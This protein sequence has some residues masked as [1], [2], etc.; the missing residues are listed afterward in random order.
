MP[1]VIKRLPEAIAN[2]I[3]AGEVVQRPASVIKELMENAV[4]AGASSISVYVSDAGK[5]LIQVLDD[6]QGMSPEDAELCFERHATSKIATIEDLF[7]IRTKGFRGEALASI[8]SIARVELKTCQ[9]DSEVGTRILM[10]GGKQQTKEECQAP[11]GTSISVQH[12]FYNVP[13][14]RNFLKSNTVE[15]RH[16]VDEFQRIALAHP[17]IHFRLEHNG[18]ELFH[19]RPGKARQR[20]VAVLGKS[21]NEK[22][23]PVEESTS[24]LDVS[25]FVGKPENAR[26]TRGDQ[27]FFINGRYFKSPYLNHAISTLYEDLIPEK[28]FPLYVLFLELDPSR[29]D[30]NVHPTKQE[31]KF[32]DEKIVYTFVQAAVRHALSKY[33]VVPTLDFDMDSEFAN[34]PAFRKSASTREQVE[35]DNSSS[36]DS[37]A[38]PSGWHGGPGRL[39]AGAAQM[40]AIGGK[41]PWEDLFQDNQGPSQKIVREPIAGDPGR[42]LR[43]LSDMEAGGLVDSDGNPPMQIHGRY[44]FT[45]IKTGFLLVDQRT[46]HERVLFEKYCKGL[47]GRMESTQR[48][49]FPT[50][51]ELG[52]AD[53]ALMR[54]ILPEINSLGFDVQDFGQDGFVIHGFPSDCQEMDDTFAVE[55]LLEAFKTLEKDA[56]LEQRE[57]VA[58][59]LA[60]TYCIKPGR[61]MSV[62]EMKMLIDDLFACETPY[63][64]PGGQRT[65]LTFGLDELAAKF[66]KA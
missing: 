16:I 45:P 23:V 11:V 57:R 8:A 61:R 47:E 36:A 27:F 24:V 51:V 26:R 10:E 19:L 34:L 12:L 7:E 56:E 58:R 18:I 59:S 3:A 31:V 39:A 46:A 40:R 30:V 63:L 65:F 49:L 2:Q 13:A 50:T 9:A 53:A 32:E 54:D 33:S 62:E 5:E 17:G 42:T 29:V 4:D 43:I 6:G 25:G 15:T 60:S 52:P 35:V 44:I 41:A 48:Q 28:H 38:S 22:L 64:A 21:V 66:R 37:P 20:V 14:R 1:A 55:E